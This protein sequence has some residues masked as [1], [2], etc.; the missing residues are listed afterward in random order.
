MRAPLTA[1]PASLRTRST[2][3]DAVVGHLLVDLA[4]QLDEL[5]RHVELARP[6]GQVEGVH[7][8]AVAAHSRPRLEAHEAVRLGRGRLDDLPDVD[9][10]AVGEHREL[11]H[12]RDVH[13]AEDVLEQLRQLRRLGSRDAHELV[14]HEAVDLFRAVR[15]RVCEA[16]EDLRRVAQRVVGAA[17]I[18]PLGREG[19][20]EVHAG[21]Q[22]R[23]LEQGRHALARGA[24][25]GRRLDHHQLARL[26]HPGEVP[27]A[28]RQRTE[29]RLAVS[30]QRGWDADQQRVCLRQARVAGARRQPPGDL[31]QLLR[32][33]VLDVGA[34]SAIAWTF[35]GS[36]STAT[37][38]QPSRAKATA[39]GSP[40]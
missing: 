27:R 35:W 21:A 11:V 8:Q 38:S 40:T 10:H 14:A 3:A 7:R 20:V 16:A 24:R 39:S 18:D 37:T 32:R 34:P 22:A 5:G 2:F 33:N 12:E 1:S 13:R 26:E 23:L 9:P 4:G 29:V 17:R 15:A 31:A 30:R 36:M 25:E 28:A 6:P 19:Q